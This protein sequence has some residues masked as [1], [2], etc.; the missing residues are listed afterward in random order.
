MLR[1]RAR[2]VP[3]AKPMKALLFEQLSAYE[4]DATAATGQSSRAWQQLL[5]AL[6][7]AA[8]STLLEGALTRRD[9]TLLQGRAA[10]SN[11]T[12]PAYGARLRTTP[13]CTTP[14]RC[15]SRSDHVRPTFRGCGAQLLVAQV[16][17]QTGNFSVFSPLEK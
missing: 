2:L 5:A 4:W 10:L 14:R 12:L 7:V 17:A 13:S 11:S 3:S 15:A 1:A 9:A 16:S 6:G 8:N